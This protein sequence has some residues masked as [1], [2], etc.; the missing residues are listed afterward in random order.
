[1]SAVVMEHASP[2]QLSQLL[3]VYLIVNV[4]LIELVLMECVRTH[5]NVDPM[6]SAEWQ[7][8]DQSVLVYQDMM[9]IQK[10]NAQEVIIFI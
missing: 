5:V 9:E 8:I 3:D 2:Y 7:N 10:L 1:M 4:L 6:L